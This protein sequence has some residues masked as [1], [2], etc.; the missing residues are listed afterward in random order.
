VALVISITYQREFFDF[1]KMVQDQL[2]MWTLV[3]RGELGNV[4]SF[5]VVFRS[6]LSGRLC[7]V[8]A[9]IPSCCVGEVFVLLVKWEIEE[10]FRDGILAGNVLIR[11]AMTSY[12]KES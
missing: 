10:C 5:I 12:I 8:A 4:V 1:F 7:F 2:W 11:E 9:E 6:Q 3:F